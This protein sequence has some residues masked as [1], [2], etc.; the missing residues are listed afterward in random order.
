[1]RLLKKCPKCGEFPTPQY[2]QHLFHNEAKI[3]C[4]KCSKSTD[5]RIAIFASDALDKAKEDWDE[6]VTEEEN[7]EEL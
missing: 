4:P 2:I 6:M 1:M 7:Q 5:W 3:I